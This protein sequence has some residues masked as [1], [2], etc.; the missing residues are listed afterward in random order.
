[1]AA[2]DRKPDQTIFVNSIPS[3]FRVQSGLFIKI[4]MK[5]VFQGKY[6]SFFSRPIVWDEKKVT[7]EVKGEGHLNVGKD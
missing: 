3:L 2:S 1:M 5:P 4:R 7:R 6:F